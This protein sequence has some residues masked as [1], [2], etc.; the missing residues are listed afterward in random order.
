MMWRYIQM[1]T[2]K[3]LLIGIAF[4][5]VGCGGSSCV[6]WDMFLLNQGFEELSNSNYLEAESY[7]RAALAETNRSYQKETPPFPLA[8]EETCGE[9]P[10][11]DSA[12]RTRSGSFPNPHFFWT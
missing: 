11:N 7:L 3:L 1:K 9:L 8:C 2:T 6:A 5:L 4:V 12:I 10:E